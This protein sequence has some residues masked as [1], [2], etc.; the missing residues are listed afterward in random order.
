MPVHDLK[1]FNCYLKLK[2][3]KTKGLLVFLCLFVGAG[4][5]SLYGQNYT[6]NGLSRWVEIGWGTPVF[7]DGQM[8]DYVGGVV[9]LHV[10][11]HFDKDGNYVWEVYQSKG[12]ATSYWTGEKF[13]YKE[14][15]IFF[16]SNMTNAWKYH[17]KGESGSHYIGEAHVV[18]SEW[19][20]TPGKTVCH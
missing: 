13:N 14:T 4:L 19:I 12:E 20:F 16:L 6:P 15:G 1:L 5:T 10:V 17:L 11:K 2:I 7:C 9:K 3:M 8:I 18:V